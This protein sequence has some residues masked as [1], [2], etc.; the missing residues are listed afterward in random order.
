MRM[1]ME[2]SLLTLQLFGTIGDVAP[3]IGENRSIV[4]R[5]LSR[6]QK[7]AVGRGWPCRRETEKDLRESDPEN[8]SNEEM[9]V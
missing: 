5:F 8:Q 1:N 4:K 9:R 7:V 6:Y 3:L 2:W